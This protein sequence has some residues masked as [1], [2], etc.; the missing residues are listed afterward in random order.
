VESDLKLKVKSPTSSTE[1]P[2]TDGKTS[3]SHLPAE[4]DLEKEK[5]PDR[6]DNP[7]TQRQLSHNDL[8]M[9]TAGDSAN[10]SM[11]I[12]MTDIPKYPNTNEESQKS[13]FKSA[14]DAFDDYIKFQNQTINSFQGVF[15][16]ILDTTTNMFLTSQ[17]F[18]GRVLEM[19]SRSSTIYTEN[20][21]A[22]GKMINGIATANISAFKSLFSAPKGT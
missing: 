5:T 8:L 19:Y 7:L 18:W 20:T 9:E 11:G 22:L 3:N 10:K 12:K 13:A 1:V 21:V 6:P 15:I 16:P 14:K 4:S 17:T 2:L